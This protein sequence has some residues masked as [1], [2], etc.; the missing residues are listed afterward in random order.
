MK[1]KRIFLLFSFLLL[2]CGCEKDVEPENGV[3]FSNLRNAPFVQISDKKLPAWL[4]QKINEIETMHNDD[5][6]TAV[7][8]FKGEWNLQTIY[9]ISDNLSSCLFCEVYFE[10]GERVGWSAY[11]GS[12]NFQST[13]K[14]WICLYQFGK[15]W[16][17]LT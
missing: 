8:I 5:F 2:F 7:G 4:R 15:G 11:G 16:E 1:E 9:Y 12:S 3:L 17:F 10:N 6:I 14:N 13:S